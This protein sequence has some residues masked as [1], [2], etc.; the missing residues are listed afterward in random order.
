MTKRIFLL[1]ATGSI[2]T[3]TLEL[4]R[5]TPEGQFELAGISANSNHK[6]LLQIQ[7][8]FQVP[9]VHLMNPESYSIASKEAGEFQLAT[10]MDSLLQMLKQSEV[11]LVLAAMVGNVGL[12]PVLYSLELGYT[13]ALANKETLV[14][15]G[16]LV[17]EL[18]GEDRSRLIP[19]DSE[20]S[21]IY[22]CLQGEKSETVDKLILTAS[23]G[24]FR[25]YCM[26]QLEQVQVEDALK[27]PNWDMGAK[28][29]VDSSSMMNKGLEVLEAHWLFGLP[30]E[31][32]EVVVHPQSIVH[33]MVEFQDRSV[34]A[35]LGLPDMTIPISYA[36]QGAN[37]TPLPQLSSLDLVQ[38][39]RLDF[40]APDTQ[41]FENLQLA[42]D[43]GK[44]GGSAPT[45]LNAANEVAVQAFLDH[46]I[47]FLQIPQLNRK[48]LE[49]HKHSSHPD[50]QEILEIDQKTREWT[51]SELNRMQA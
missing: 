33:S 46:R 8:E 9:F 30:F 41:R 44:L 28:I 49:N 45:V 5:N 29:T 40:E 18:L 35:H 12:Q 7:S 43:A 37:R 26:E 1:G 16:H 4:L 47:S 10:G 15:G 17:A 32:I 36:L 27:H 48:A 31:K 3:T 11:D 23:G 50:L 38:I 34:I 6:A 42:Y 14:A 51:I 25:T 2:G 21:A 19:V 20:H 22:Q 39:G 24:S 13:V